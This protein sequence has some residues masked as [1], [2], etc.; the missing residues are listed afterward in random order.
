MDRKKVRF[1]WWGSMIDVD[2]VGR[3]RRAC[4]F[5][6]RSSLGPQRFS[7][8]NGR[9]R[10]PCSRQ[11]RKRNRSSR[12]S[13][14]RTEK[15]DSG[16]DGQWKNQKRKSRERRKRLLSLDSGFDFLS[17]RERQRERPTPL[18]LL[19][20]CCVKECSFLLVTYKK[21]NWRARSKEE[22]GGGLTHLGAAA[23]QPFAAAAKET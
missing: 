16:K 17:E 3:M 11:L 23:K 12:T 13:K 14:E 22:E 5:F 6:L 15:M 7:P 19:N 2:V 8:T 18:F 10:N 4:F 1:K 9:T 21:K 20:F